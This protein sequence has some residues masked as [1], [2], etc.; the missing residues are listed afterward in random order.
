VAL[1]LTCPLCKA[2]YTVPDEARGK[3][4]LCRSC[5]GA[6]AIPPAAPD[7]AISARRSSPGPAAM[8]RGRA[9]EDR[10]AAAPRRPRRKQ[11]AKTGISPAVWIGAGVGG[12]ALIG[13]VVVLILVLNKGSAETPASPVVAQNQ[14]APPAAPPQQP[15]NNGNN[16]APVIPGPQG[17]AAQPANGPA[18][19]GEQIYK[20][21]LK[22]TV[23]IVARQKRG[24]NVAA[25]QPVGGPPGAGGGGGDLVGSSWSGSETLAGYGRLRFD[26]QAGGRATMVDAKETVAG[27]FTVNGQSVTVTFYGGS[28]VYSGRINGNQMAGTANNGRNTWTWNLTRG[29]AVAGGPF[30]NPNP[31]PGGFVGGPNAGIGGMPNPGFTGIAG[32]PNPG[33]AGIAGRPGFA[34]IGG[35]PNFVGGPNPGGIAG[36]AGRPNFVGGPNPGGIAGIAGRPPGFPNPGIGGMPHPGFPNPAGIAGIA[37]RPPGFPNPGFPGPPGGLPGVPPVP[38]PFQPPGG[39]LPG[40]A[41]QMTIAVSA[42]TGS[43]IDRKNRLIVTNCH[44]VGQPEEV[45]IYFPEFA[46]G[47]LVAKRD[48]YKRRPGLRGRVVLREERIDLALIQIDSLPNDVKV[49]Q[50]APASARPAQQVHSV[51]NPGASAA[52]WIYSPGRVRQVFRDTWK[53]FDDLDNKTYTYN[54]MKLETDSPINPGDSGGPLVNDRGLMVGVAHATQLDA[55]NMSS[56]IDVTEVRG[57]IQRYYQNLGQAWVPDQ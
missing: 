4:V 22:S 14:D 48:D 36:I 19:D 6:I 27:T 55:Q 57:L 33:F 30:P 7:M 53:V 52:L 29:V 28:V 38:V 13:L 1:R 16:P 25:G 9:D 56:F 2:A 41:P 32:R 43:L 21:L 40:G 24:I 49:L 12:V 45:L 15:A 10:D 3:T 11:E 47:E 37:G 46:N 23:W 42:G 20:N 50:L 35:R 26:F 44:V 39:G 51:G 8:P 5:K 18:L 54:G 17:P 31:N 34:G